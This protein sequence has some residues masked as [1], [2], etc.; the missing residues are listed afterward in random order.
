MTDDL[1]T[2]VSNSSKRESTP[3]RVALI[4]LPVLLVAGAVVWWLAIR[5]DASESSSGHSGTTFVVFF[6]LPTVSGRAQGGWEDCSA[7]STFGPFGPGEI[8]HI[9]DENGDLIGTETTMGLGELTESWRGILGFPE[10]YY[11][12]VQQLYPYSCLVWASVETNRSAL[13]YAI[14]MG[15]GSKSVTHDELMQTE[16]EVWVRYQEG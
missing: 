7:S 4:A 2:Q 10:D 16:F 3:R 12:S 9:Y 1:S 5:G 14:A 8:V 15:G 13:T 6:E 11:Q